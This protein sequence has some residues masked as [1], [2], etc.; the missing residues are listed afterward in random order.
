MCVYEHTSLKSVTIISFKDGHCS[1]AMDK[2]TGYRSGE[3]KATEALV[4]DNIYDMV[5]Y[6]YRD[7]L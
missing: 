1:S 6:R 5:S 7:R 2:N 3:H 4:C